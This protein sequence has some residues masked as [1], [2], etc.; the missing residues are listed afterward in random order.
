[1]SKVCAHKSM[2]SNRKCT[3]GLGA[4]QD[5]IYT[6]PGRVNYIVTKEYHRIN[7]LSFMQKKMQKLVANIR[8]ETVGHVPYTYNNQPRN[9]GSPQQQQCTM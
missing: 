2:C 3:Q 6:V 1:M 7:L 8:D 5:D 9:Q 4:G